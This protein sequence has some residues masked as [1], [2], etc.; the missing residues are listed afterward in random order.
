VFNQIKVTDPWRGARLSAFGGWG[1]RIPGSWPV[2]SPTAASAGRPDHLAPSASV[3][4][5]PGTGEVLKVPRD[6][7]PGKRTLTSTRIPAYRA[8]ITT[9]LHDLPM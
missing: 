8:S 4:F 5:K 1:R 3:D 6:A 7:E 2:R 9:K